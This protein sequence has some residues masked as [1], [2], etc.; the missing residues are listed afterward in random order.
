MH[1]SRGVPP[2]PLPRLLDERS[3]PDFRD[4]FGGLARNAIALDVAVTRIRLT[5]LQLDVGELAGLNRL[6][7][8][9]A[10]VRA[11]VLDAEAHEALLEPGRS[12][13]LRHLIEELRRGR[14]RVRAAPLGGWSPDFS[15]FHG[16]DGPLAA[17]IGPHW[18]ERPYPQRGP[19]WAAVL[20]PDDARRT[21]DRFEELWERSHDVSPALGRILDRAYASAPSGRT[22][23][24]SGRGGRDGGRLAAPAGIVGGEP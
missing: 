13:T 23:A 3:R 11:P 16:A 14:V 9:L 8:L 2:S 19:A 7:L 20:G 6:R 18:L 5:T 21:A 17:M 24:S 1:T 4:C 10:E 12:V 15:V 22:P